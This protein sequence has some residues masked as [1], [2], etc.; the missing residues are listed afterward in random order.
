[1]QDVLKSGR[2]LHVLRFVVD[3]PVPIESEFLS[4]VGIPTREK[5]KKQSVL[6]QHGWNCWC[7]CCL[8]YNLIHLP[9]AVATV[10]F[11][12]FWK[13]LFSSFENRSRF[14]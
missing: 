10:P 2:L 9:F 1:M 13:S 12:F 7:C 5:L 8:G 11:F 3:L 6:S 14:S 4:L